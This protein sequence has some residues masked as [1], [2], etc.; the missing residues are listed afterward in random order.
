M[1]PSKLSKRLL[2]P[3][4]ADGQ[5]PSNTPRNNCGPH[6]SA[7]V[8]FSRPQGI[9]FYLTSSNQRLWYHVICME[10]LHSFPKRCVAGIHLLHSLT[11]RYVLTLVVLS[12]LDQHVKHFYFQANFRSKGSV[13]A[14]T[15]SLLLLYCNFLPK[16]MRCHKVLQTCLFQPCVP[17]TKWKYVFLGY[18]TKDRPWRSSN[19]TTACTQ[20]MTT[21]QQCIY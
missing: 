2:G 16:S 12:G 17:C 20:S 1:G 4:L 5:V 10:F 6:I 21:T 18:V 7:P 14:T 11:L 9:L 8:S 19:N 3:L 13:Q 15:P